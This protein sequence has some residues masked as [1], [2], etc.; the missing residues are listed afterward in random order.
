[1][2]KKKTYLRFEMLPSHGATLQF[3]V[4]GRE[5]TMRL[6]FIHWKT[7]WRRYCFFPEGDTVFDAACLGEITS[8]LGELMAAWKFARDT[9]KCLD[10]IDGN[11]TNNTPSNLRIMDIR[12]HV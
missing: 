3:V 6:G 1:M 10:H 7:H 9:N 12:E 11:P 8:F 5:G 2:A 4:L